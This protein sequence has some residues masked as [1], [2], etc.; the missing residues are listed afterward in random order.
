MVH[1]LSRTT[2]LTFHNIHLVL[3]PLVRKF[4]PFFGVRYLHVANMAAV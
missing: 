1:E 2:S 4:H 3:K